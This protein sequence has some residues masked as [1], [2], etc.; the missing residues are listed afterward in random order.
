MNH[1]LW[2]PL[3]HLHAFRRHISSSRPFIPG[4]HVLLR[5]VPPRNTSPIFTRP[6]KPGRRIETHRGLILHDDIIGKYPRELVSSQLSRRRSQDG[7]EPRGT[8]YR[9]HEVKLEEYVRLS[10]RLVTPIYP[11][12]AA[13]IVELLDLHPGALHQQHLQPSEDSESEHVPPK[14][15]ILEAGTGH[16][17]LTLYLARALHAANAHLPPPPSDPTALATWK[18]TRPAI[19]HTLDI[20]ARYSA[21]AQATITTFR[22]GLYTPTIDFH[23]SSPSPWIRAA[24]A[25]PERGGKSFLSHVILDLPNADAQLADVVKGV[26]DDGTVV[27]FNPSV[28][29]ILDCLERVKQ[30]GLALELEKVVELGAGGG[31]GGREWDCRFVKPRAGRGSE[32]DVGGEKV[33]EESGS[34]SEGDVSG[35]ETGDGVDAEGEKEVREPQAKPT[36]ERSGQKEWAMVCRPK[37]GERIVGGGFVGVFRKLR[38]A[39]KDQ[40]AGDM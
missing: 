14:L 9:I 3:R 20:S 27:V 35:E 36:S 33:M 1:P 15:E 8:N 12:D 34:G 26:R 32:A 7:K 29:Q 10:R 25:S 16:G 21:H 30:E 39:S 23:V 38:E 17:A 22:H 6:L 18:G 4:D 31:S 13:L 11:A 19:L 28:T 2:R 24:L 37:V 5:E 40:S